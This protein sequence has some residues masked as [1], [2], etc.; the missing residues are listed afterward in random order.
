MRTVQITLEDELV[1]AVDSAAGQ[2]SQSRSAF[3]RDALR[4]ALEKLEVRAREQQ[5][6]E[7]YLRH[8]VSP[9]EF[10]DIE[11]EAGVDR[12]MRRGEIR[13]Y[14][15]KTPDQKR[16]VLILTRN[17]ILEVL[18][19]VTAPLTS[20]IRHIPSE[21]IL[22]PEDG[23]PQAC[24][25]N[26]DHVQPVSKAKVGLFITAWSEPQMDRVKTALLFALGF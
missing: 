24:A 18:G 1:K 9:G 15:F 3:A 25:I 4:A 7:G 5:H 17:S 10:S 21:V 20:T 19:E 11:D 16:P 2:L 23:M 8:P 22:T 13:W 26:L 6:R 12:L 14:P